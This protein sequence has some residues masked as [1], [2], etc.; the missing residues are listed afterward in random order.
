LIGELLKQFG[1][2][3]LGPNANFLGFQIRRNLQTNQIWLKQSEFAQKIVNFYSYKGINPAD[4][5][6]RPKFQIP[7]QWKVITGAEKCHVNWQLGI[8]A[9]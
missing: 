4:T 2:K 9:T 8:A 3:L 6:W 1:L 7:I 5:P